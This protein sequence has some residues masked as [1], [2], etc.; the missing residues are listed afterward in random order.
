MTT[1]PA[2]LLFTTHKLYKLYSPPQSQFL[3]FLHSFI[4]ASERLT[5]GLCTIP[6]HTLT[7]VHSYILCNAVPLRVHLFITAGLKP[8]DL[9]GCAKGVGPLPCGFAEIECRADQFVVG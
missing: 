2:R 4:L 3:E 9:R 1:A 7:H 5:I 8:L 6:Y